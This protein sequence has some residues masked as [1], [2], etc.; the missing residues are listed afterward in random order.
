RDAENALQNSLRLLQSVVDNAPTRFFWKDAELRYLGCNSLFAR[1]AGCS[2]PH[3]VIG[4]TDFDLAWKNQ[5]ELY[6]SDDQ[7]VIE[8]GAIKLG[9][10]EPQTTP[11][12]KQIWLRTSKVPLHDDA[13]KIVGVLGIYEDITERKHLEAQFRQAQ[14][15]EAI[16]K[17]AGGV[18]HDFNNIL[19]AMM[20]HLG[21]L[22]MNTGLDEE[23]VQGLS[24]LEAH[25]RR[26]ASLTSQLLMFG[27]RS[28]LHIKPLDV[29]EVIGNLLRM[30]H[31]LIGE[32][33]ELRFDGGDALPPVEADAGMLE[34]I[35]V[36]LVVNA[37]DAMPRGGRILIQTSQVTFDPD[38]VLANESRRPGTFVRVS[39][40]D[41]GC[42]MAPEIVKHI[43]EPFFTTKDVGKGTGLGLATVHGIAAQHHGWVEVEST[44]GQGTTFQLHFP[45]RTQPT[46]AT[47]GSTVEPPLA[48]GGG[49]T[50]L[51]V[52]DDARLRDLAARTLR[53]LGYQI[54]EAST[55]IEAI[56]VW[57][58]HP[59]RVNLLLTDMVMPEG[60]SGL[61][62]AERLREQ[63]PGL[64]VI[65]SSGYSAEIVQAGVPTKAGIVYLPKPYAT[66]TL[67]DAVRRCLE[68][69]RPGGV[70]DPLS[71]RTDPGSA[72]TAHPRSTASDDTPRR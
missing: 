71:P 35:L 7:T 43:F 49:E 13:G 11:D 58:A 5:A 46:S 18:A 31:R 61:E 15:L 45:A 20:M 39:V 12:G 72:A 1:D 33:V 62:L 8:T 56:Q 63:R 70:P 28:V 47:N 14:K 64:R 40:S 22:R 38:V 51:L 67:A 50:I 4:K 59:Q 53:A 68:L 9:Y 41:T 17:L 23:T 37:R 54:L 21:L 3:E 19:A 29:N 69:A 65:I 42:G 30:L 66:S 2:S 44:V 55:G 32:Q 26:A 24:E 27:R 34:Q 6:R 36:N 60:M 10:E 52:E 16:G 57:N 48:R 25:A